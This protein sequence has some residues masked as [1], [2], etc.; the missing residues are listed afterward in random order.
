MFFRTKLLGGG[1]YNDARNDS[2][3]PQNRGV[4]C[5]NL[6][7]KRT[8]WQIAIL[9]MFV[10]CFCF[11]QFSPLFGN[12]NGTQNIGAVTPTF[13]IST[14]ADLITLDG[15]QTYLTEQNYILL[16]NDITID[17][18]KNGW[19]NIGNTT[20]GFQGTFDGNGHTITIIDSERPMFRKIG[21][22]GTIKDLTINSI[23][24]NQ[25][26]CASGVFTY[27][28]Y[29]L[30]SNCTSL[31]KIYNTS[32]MGSGSTAGIVNDNYGKIFQ[33]INKTEITHMGSEDYGYAYIGGICSSNQ[34]G[35]EIISCANYGKFTVDSY[36]AGGISAENRGLIKNCYNYGEMVSAGTAICGGI[37]AEAS[38][39]SGKKGTIENC[40]NAG[41]F[42]KLKETNNLEFG[43]ILGRTI[44]SSGKV[45]MTINN[46]FNVGFASTNPR[47]GG[48]VGSDAESVAIITYSAFLMS[49]GNYDSGSIKG[50]TDLATKLSKANPDNFKASAGYFSEDWD[51]KDT[52]T[53]VKEYDFPVLKAFYPLTN[54]KLTL[55]TSF[56]KPTTYGIVVHIMKDG[57]NFVQFALTKTQ[58]HLFTLECGH[59]YSLIIVKPYLYKVN[60]DG[61]T[62]ANKYEFPLSIDAETEEHTIVIN[63][64]DNVN[65]VVVI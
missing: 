50:S 45:V 2:I 1:G 21:T 39:S 35:G 61:V 24:N 47:S 11:I 15:T 38:G 6:H 60:F 49:S 13:E 64:V 4:Y 16:K 8:K 65:S 51:F 22:K 41:S 19:G 33:C 37:V 9:T 57:T 29:G 54:C 20:D 63:V 59:E 36:Y 52:W 31:G 34:E 58:T 10:I 55:T 7:H 18:S 23:D 42:T 53:F 62:Y 32:D 43:G 5:Q 25:Y 3:T 28:N 26:Y 30:I 12:H 17:C 48:I 14:E 44:G 56:D 27:Y 40:Y 46:C